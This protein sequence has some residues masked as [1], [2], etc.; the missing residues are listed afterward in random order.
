MKHEQIAGEIRAVNEPSAKS[1]N[2][3]VFR[4]SFTPVY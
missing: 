3:L 1:I 4:S 2:Q